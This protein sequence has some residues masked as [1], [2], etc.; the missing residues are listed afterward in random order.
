MLP[1]RHD[2]LMVAE[3]RWLGHLLLTDMT[4]GD[5]CEASFCHHL[6]R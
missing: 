5:D 2:Q 3:E 4:A 6:C 1:V